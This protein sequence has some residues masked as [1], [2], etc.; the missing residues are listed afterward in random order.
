MGNSTSW[1]KS[2]FDRT[3]TSEDVASRLLTQEESPR[4]KFGQERLPGTTTDPSTTSSASPPSD[5]P[6]INPHIK[7]ASNQQ[8]GSGT[9]F[10]ISS[11]KQVMK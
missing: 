5:D 6:P 2:W 1:I 9:G 7:A 10:R 11:M 8:A 4:S 3:D